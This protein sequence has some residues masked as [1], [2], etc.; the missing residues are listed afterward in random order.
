MR[1][2]NTVQIKEQ[3]PLFY[4]T[5][6]EG[7]YGRWSTGRGTKSDFLAYD[8]DTK[9]KYEDAERALCKTDRT[10]TT[11]LKGRYLLCRLFDESTITRMNNRWW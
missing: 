10:V 6:R 5:A 1:Q 9:G 11:N 2:S 8:K 7:K 3:R 4:K